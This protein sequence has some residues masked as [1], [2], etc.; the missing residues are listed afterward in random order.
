MGGVSSIQFFLG[1]MNFAKPFTT[2]STQLMTGHND[3]V[4]WLISI[5]PYTSQGTDMD[6]NEFNVPQRD[7]LSRSTAKCENPPCLKYPAK[8]TRWR[9]H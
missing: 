9:Y 4:S 3:V 7:V 8:E 1:F 2:S 5:P 6:D